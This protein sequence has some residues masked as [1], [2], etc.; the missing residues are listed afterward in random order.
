MAACGQVAR[1]DCTVQIAA[2]PSNRPASSRLIRVV[3][4]P[5]CTMEDMRALQMTIVV[6]I[7][8]LISI[9]WCAVAQGLHA[10]LLDIDADEM[11]DVLRW[12]RSAVANW[13]TF[14][15]A[16]IA[17]TACLFLAAG[18]AERHLALRICSGETQPI[19]ARHEAGK[20]DCMGQPGAS[21]AARNA[22]RRRDCVHLPIAPG[23]WLMLASALSFAM[24]LAAILVVAWL[25]A[26]SRLP[27]PTYRVDANTSHSRL[28]TNVGE[29]T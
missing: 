25:L 24:L 27:F 11:P 28:V 26:S 23:G 22:P 13:E 29:M 15:A 7:F 17:L 12:I 3:C 20:P 10:I 4:F 8:L 19:D 21:D 1:S 18:F 9:C 6:L 14:G 2:A 16:C 5:R